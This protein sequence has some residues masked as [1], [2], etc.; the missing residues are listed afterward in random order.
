MYF[1]TLAMVVSVGCGSLDSQYV[2]GDRLTYDVIAP[3]HLDYL[4]A[5]EALDDEQKDRRRALLRSWEARLLEGE[6]RTE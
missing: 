4:E 2:T 3:T 1:A 6:D 5:D